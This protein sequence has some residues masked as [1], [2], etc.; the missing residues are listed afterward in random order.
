M[1]LQAMRKGYAMKNLRSRATSVIVLIALMVSVVALPAAA[2]ASP[3]RDGGG[4]RVVGPVHNDRKPDPLT[5]QQLSLKKKA[6]EAKLNGKAYGKTAEVARGQYVELA[7]EGEGA[8]WTVLG[9]FA[10]LPHN[11]IPEPDRNYDNTTIWVPDFSRS[12][13]MDL[14]FNDAKGAN[15]MRNFYI[16][17]SS[18]RYAVYGD[19]TD[20]VTCPGTAESYDDNPDSNVWNFLED[21]LNGWYDMQIAAGKTPAEINAYLAQFDVWDRYDY[22]GDGEFNEPDGY[23]DTF[24]SVHAGE[25]EEAGGGVLG[26]KAIWSHSWY[27][28]Y[29]L[30]GVAGPDFNK[31]G[32]IR[33]GESDFWIGKYTIQPENGGVGVFVHEYAHDM[34]LPD[35]YDY[36]GENGTGFWTLMSSGSWL[37]DGKDTIGNKSSHMG[38]WEKFQLGWLNYEVARAGMKSQHRLGP[39]EFNTKQAQGVFVVL[40][41]K[42]VVTDLGAPYAG[43][44]YYYSGMGDDLDNKMYKSFELAPGSMLTAKVRYEIELDW[45]YAYLVVSTDGGAT[46]QSIETNL[47]TTSDP[48]GQNFGYG[49]TGS[50]GGDWVDLTADLSAYNGPVMLGF[51]YWTDGAVSEAGL[52]IDEI[53]V[54][55]YPIDGAEA[56]AGWTFAPASGFRVTTG[57]EEA[58]K[59]HYYVLE[60]RTYKGYDSTLKVG[61]YYFGYLDDPMRGNWVDHYAYQ[62]GL[63]IN[64][65]DTSQ[66]DNNT[67]L[68]PGH[69]LLLPVDAH[70][71][72]LY[73][74]DGPRWRNR[75]QTYDATFGL[76][77]TDGIPNIH[78]NSVLSPVPSL[79]A[80]PVF[81]DTKSW[82]D[83]ANPLGS[84]ITPNTG[85]MVKVTS[86][87]PGNF[88]QVQV[89]PV[90]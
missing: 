27:A 41:K 86:F 83:P 59:S 50:S 68:H 4:G 65:W 44:H 8:V 6:L 55:G 61:P 13:F 38:A 84:V 23:I 9:E 75:I 57:T 3:A 34:G 37:D 78:H 10:D 31:L 62:D 47:S 24:Q 14:L 12:Y 79:P 63:L 54:T 16:E 70:P 40:P 29:N 53:S 56:D 30:I 87:T 45:D 48:N 90:K 77:K 25:G 39:M 42:R 52:M 60:Y 33:I 80:V 82:Y 36:Y 85:T 81:D 43:E 22:D 88:M 49:I 21:S 20:W 17:Q 5:T 46:W 76:E 72:T 26:D 18:G 35:L 66:S 51:R 32:G 58:L 1:G 74:I 71:A 89:A 67:A 73:R 2:A 64:Y 19:V 69:G 15:S 11:S 7:R 28:R